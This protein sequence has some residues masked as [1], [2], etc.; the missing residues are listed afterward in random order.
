LTETCVFG[1]NDHVAQHR[2]LTTTTE[3]VAGY[4][5][6][7]RLAHALGAVP[8]ADGVALEHVDCRGVGHF[9]D[10][11]AGGEDGCAASDDDGAN[12]G[13]GIVLLEGVDELDHQRSSERIELLGPIEG[14]DADRAVGGRQDILRHSR[15]VSTP[16]G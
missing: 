3:R 6:D 16:V 11:R 12:R 9:A 5:R 10:V 4:C 1:G 14:D 8:Q 7:Q 15:R 13:V 2:Q